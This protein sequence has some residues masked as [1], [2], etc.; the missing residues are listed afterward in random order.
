MFPP[1][2]IPVNA[3]TV[4]SRSSVTN[5]D[6]DNDIVMEAYA[7]LVYIFSVI[8]VI[9]MHMTKRV[10]TVLLATQQ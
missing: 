8:P 9:C 5:L 3:G 4:V 1:A 2:V 7:V 6:F 10:T